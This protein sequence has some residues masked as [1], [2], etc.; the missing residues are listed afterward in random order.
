MSQSKEAPFNKHSVTSLEGQPFEEALKWISR[1]TEELPSGI[2]TDRIEKVIQDVDN[3]FNGHFPGYLACDTHYHSFEHTL[4]LFPPFCQLAV[5]LSRK[6]PETI[7]P[8]DIELGLIAVFLHDTGYIRND[9]DHSGTGAKYTFR[10][11][12]R[13]INFAY[14]YLPSLGYQEQDL[15]RVEQMISCTGVKPQVEQ[16]NFSSEGC[17]LLGYAL[18]TADLLGQM[19]DHR[20]PE[21]LPLLFLEFQEAYSYEGPESLAEM[22][23]QRFTSEKE[24]IQNTPNFFKNLIHKRLEDMGGVYHLLEDPRKNGTKSLSGKDPG[25]YEHNILHTFLSP[26]AFSFRHSPI[27]TVLPPAIY[28]KVVESLS[29]LK[30]ISPPIPSIEAV[31]TAILSM[32]VV[33][34][35]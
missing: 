16:I 26:I 35:Q 7:T 13:S 33:L 28:V 5:A 11:I 24:L 23:I 10:H 32:I 4:L 19:S 14:S 25:K 3:L 12:D 6:Y 30:G 34:F 9:E 20:Y 27:Y 15:V 17:R 8:R 21:K 29:P 22:E 31:K 2:S 1:V 18:G